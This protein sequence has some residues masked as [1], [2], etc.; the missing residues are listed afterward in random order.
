MRQIIIAGNWKMHKTVA[1]AVSFVQELKQKELNPAVQVVVCPPFTALAP[2]AEV[3]KGSNIALAA[4]NMHWESQGAF[5]GEVSPV[6]LKELGCQYVILGHSERRQYF[7]ETDETVN[8]KVKAA[9][10]QGLIPI[11]CVGETLEQREAGITEQVVASQTKGALQGLTAEQVAGLVIAYEPVWAI[12]TG[13]TASAEDAQQVNRYIRQVVASEFGSAAA[14]AVRIQ[15]G[16]S[17]KASNAKGLMSQPD[18]D[19]GLVGGA[20]LKVEDFVGII[21]NSL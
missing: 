1:E 16:G 15:Y 6:M 17:V 3:L 7:G 8:R 10:A 11:V 18:I 14:E 12:G 19:G 9:L 20:S 13:K 2:V 4:Q 5:T 21:E